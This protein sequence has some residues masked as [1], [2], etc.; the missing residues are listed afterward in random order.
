MSDT[1]RRSAELSSADGYSRV[2]TM[3]SELPD[4]ARDLWLRI[5]AGCYE[6]AERVG[7]PFAKRWVRGVEEVPLNLR[8]LETLRH[9]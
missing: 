6:T 5:A 8:K 3:S 4:D 1:A 9:P 7:E 2:M